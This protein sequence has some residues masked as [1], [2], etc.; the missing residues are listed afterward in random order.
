V[1]SFLV[2]IGPLRP[3]L[4]MKMKFHF[5]FFSRAAHCTKLVYE[6]VSKSS[7]TG[8]RERELQMVQLSATTCSCIAILCV[9]VVS[10]AAISLCFAS[11]RV[12]IVVY[13]AMDSVRKLLDTPSY[14]VDY[15][16]HLY[17]RLSLQTFFDYGL[18]LTKCVYKE[19]RQL[20]V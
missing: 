10:F 6:G 15:T 14:N 19:L 2:H 17:L 5:F 13:F 16:V 9:S 3:Q 20:A 4:Y 7:R 8:G 1:N 12:F 11:Q 18:Y